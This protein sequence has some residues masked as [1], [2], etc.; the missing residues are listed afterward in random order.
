MITDGIKELLIV[1]SV[2]TIVVFVAMFADLIAGLWK[3]NTR[4]DRRTSYAL[5]R[6]VYK[7]LTYE[8]AMIVGGCIDVLMNLA[9]LFELIGVEALD[10]V[11]VVAL[12]VGIFLCA[13][14]LMSIREKAD[15]KTHKTMRKV[16]DAAGKVGDKLLD[17]LVE[18][19]SERL[20]KKE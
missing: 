4:G 20:K 2:A 12:L 6:S 18:A 9:N 10:N 13:V 19:I 16:E 15:D 14:E 8:G 7:F 11:P 17:S 3:A 5:K 1:L